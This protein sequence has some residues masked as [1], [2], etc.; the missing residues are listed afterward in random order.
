MG[1]SIEC[2]I[3]MVSVDSD[4]MGGGQ[5]DMSP[6]V[7]S[8]NNCKEFSVMDIV[9]S[10]CLVEGMGYTSNGLELPPVIFLGED[11]PCRKLRCVHF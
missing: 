2:E 3:F 5:K 8:V 7:K 6:G 9:I 4:D 1:R 10:F 11:G